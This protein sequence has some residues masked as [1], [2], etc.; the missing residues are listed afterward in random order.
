M[1]ALSDVLRVVQLTGGVF[2]EAGFTAPWCVWSRV[3]PEDCQPFLVTPRHLLAY[4]CVLEGRMVVGL[5]DGSPPLELE[6]GG[7]V[8]LPRNPRHRVGSSLDVEPIL[9][10][11]LVQ[12]PVD[13][14][15][16]RIEQGGRGEL[17]RFVCGFLGCD[18]PFNPL[19]SA[20]PEALT[21]DLRGTPAGA[22][23]ES[24]F[25]FAAAQRGRAPPGDMAVMTRLSELL[26]VEALRQHLGRLPANERGWLAGLRDPVVGRALALMHAGF[27]EPWTAET[28]AQA[29]HLSRSAFAERFTGLVGRPPMQYLAEWR[30][31]RAGRLLKES[32]RSVAQVAADVGYES[33]AAF[34]RAFKR[35]HGASP[36][37]WRRRSRS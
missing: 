9:A 8:L 32:P 4:H 16:A 36:A 23:M 1:D 24:S 11:D 25:R 18:A 15:L 37:E 35:H 7:V 2:L 13:G 31:L 19:L 3:G 17:T 34:S 20:L 29:V 28:L 33:E 14:G 22:W 10:D 27:A 21:L 5:E 6:A 26:F 30:M 12:A